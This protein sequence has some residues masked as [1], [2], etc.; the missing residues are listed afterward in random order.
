MLGSFLHANPQA[1]ISVTG[2]HQ[3]CGSLVKAGIFVLSFSK[4][5]VQHN[6][7]TA[8]STRFDGHRCIDLNFNP[9]SRIAV[10]FIAYRVGNTDRN[11]AAVIASSNNQTASGSR[12]RRRIAIQ[13][14]NG[15]IN[16]CEIGST[17]P[18]RFRMEIYSM[19]IAVVPF[20]SGYNSSTRYPVSETQIA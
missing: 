12:R 4:S 5:Q 10:V 19:K 11:A 20:R 15:C 16:H 8:R 7:M 18:L 17:S 1:G 3:D 13:H 9:A 14:L 2:F 6:S